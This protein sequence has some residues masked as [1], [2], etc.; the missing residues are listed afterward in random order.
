LFTELGVQ[1]I[2]QEFESLGQRSQDSFLL[3]VEFVVTCDSEQAFQHIEVVQHT[4]IEGVNAL[5]TLSAVS[6]QVQCLWGNDRLFLLLFLLV[7]LG[8][9]ILLLFAFAFFGLCLL[10]LGD[11]NDASIFEYLHED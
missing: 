7:S 5:D 9:A 3:S 8:F 4:V 11:F 2:D 1:Q 6:F 10:D